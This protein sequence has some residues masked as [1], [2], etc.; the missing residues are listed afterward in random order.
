[1]IKIYCPRC[2]WVADWI[3]YNN[4]KCD[5]CM[6]FFKVF[7]NLEKESGVKSH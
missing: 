3:A 5:R 7:G 4:F 1:M 6:E 2:R